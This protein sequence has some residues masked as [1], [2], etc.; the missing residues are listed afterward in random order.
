MTTCGHDDWRNIMK[1]KEEL[2]KEVKEDIEIFGEEYEVY[3]AAML[4]PGELKI[5]G[6]SINQDDKYFDPITLGDLLEILESE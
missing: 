3:M 4:I 6:Y 5:Y 2:I 1:T